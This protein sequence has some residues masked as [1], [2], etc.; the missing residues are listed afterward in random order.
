MVVRI[1]LPSSFPDSSM[2]LQVLLLYPPPS[3]T[4]ARVVRDLE[5]QQCPPYPLTWLKLQDE[6]LDSSGSSIR[7][8]ST[9]PLLG[10]PRPESHSRAD[11]VLEPSNDHPEI[12]V[13]T[14]VAVAPTKPST[15]STTR[16]RESSRAWKSH[17]V[18]FDMTHE[19]ATIPHFDSS[20][21]S[22]QQ[23]KMLTRSTIKTSAHAHLGLISGF[24]T[25]VS[26]RLSFSS[27]AT[28]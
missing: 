13:A 8:A 15:R 9:S 5:Q 10:H 25:T 3:L 23:R 27:N 20:A 16:N 1:P 6:A 11:N 19:V 17:N 22:D 24:E 18:T 7:A 14:T 4:P 28:R 21:E 12:D 2:P 26:T